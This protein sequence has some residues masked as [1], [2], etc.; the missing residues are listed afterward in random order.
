M[1]VQGIQYHENE[2]GVRTLQPTCIRCRFC[3]CGFAGLVNC[4]ATTF[5]LA[6]PRAGR[7]LLGLCEGNFCSGGK[8][9]RTKGN[10]RIVLSKYYK[11][12]KECG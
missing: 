5:R 7:W 11:N 4:A 1:S 9:G 8:H 3:D 10:G 2:E 6:L 12:D